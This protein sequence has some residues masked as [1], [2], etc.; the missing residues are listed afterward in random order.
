MKN[1]Q[2][3]YLEM[4]NYVRKIHPNDKGILGKKLE[5]SLEK[6]VKEL[7]ESVTNSSR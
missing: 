3:N 6:K 5:E 2:E 7:K 1:T 4:L